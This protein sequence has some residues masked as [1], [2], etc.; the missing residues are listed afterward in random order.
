MTSDVWLQLWSGTI[1]AVVGAVVGGVSAILVLH[2]SNKH[3]S[4]LSRIALDLQAEGL[5]DQLSAQR[6]ERRETREIEAVA[7]LLQFTTKLLHEEPGDLSFV[8]ELVRRCDQ[9]TLNSSDEVGKHWRTTSRFDTLGV[10]R[11]PYA[12][13][14]TVS[15]ALNQVLAVF[16]PAMDVQYGGEL[17]ARLR[18]LLR[19]DMVSWKGMTQSLGKV[20]ACLLRWQFMSVE[21]KIAVFNERPWAEKAAANFLNLSYE[22]AWSDGSS[23][24]DF[25]RSDKIDYRIQD[26]FKWVSAEQIS[27]AA[28]ATTPIFQQL[29]EEACIQDSD[30]RLRRDAFWM[31]TMEVVFE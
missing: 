13:S 8:A 16:I 20:S 9:L 5:K 18:H 25:W 10:S 22:L 26:L 14:L 15:I 6:E 24:Q 12:E 21:E 17:P 7:E 27:A 19:E 29:F 31:K 30:L 4:A 3:Q 11:H 1:G 28:E 2:F 23:E